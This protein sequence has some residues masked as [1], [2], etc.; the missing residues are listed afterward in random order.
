LQRRKT[1]TR[2]LELGAAALAA[3]CLS[4]CGGE[5]KRASPPPPTL[6]RALASALAARSDAVVAALAAGDGCGALASAQLLQRDTIAAINAGRVSAAFQEELASAV[7]DLATR[8]SCVPAEVEH[9]RGK[10]KR[11]H[12]KK[13]HGKDD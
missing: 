2:P 3:L 7:N 12:E 13:K 5:T 9:D 6:P 11:E 8:V 4:A 1:R 10:P